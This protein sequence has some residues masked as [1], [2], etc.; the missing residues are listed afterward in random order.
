MGTNR[1]G[2]VLANDNTT[3]T[4]DSK[5]DRRLIVDTASVG[6]SECGRLDKLLLHKVRSKK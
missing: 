2:R 3:A 4:L 5:S 1:Y 6:P